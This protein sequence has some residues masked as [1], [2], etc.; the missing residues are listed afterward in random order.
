VNAMDQVITVIGKIANAWN[1]AEAAALYFKAGVLGAVALVLQGSNL[2][3]Q[4]LAK[5]AEVLGMEA[6]AGFADGFDSVAD[7][8]TD[9]ASDAAKAANDALGK[10]VGGDGAKRVETWFDGLKVDAAKI[11]DELSAGI[12]GGSASAAGASAN[13]TSEFRQVDLQRVFI[14]GPQSAATSITRGEQQIVSQQK[15]TNSYLMIMSKRGLVV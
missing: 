11:A 13:K 9:A 2:I 10:F 8:F 15:T 1:L 14:G 3:V 5:V 6:M 12:G 4:A 7:R